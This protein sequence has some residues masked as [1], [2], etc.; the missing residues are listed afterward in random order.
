[1]LLVLCL[2]FSC[3]KDILT[4]TDPNKGNVTFW[5]SE[6]SGEV[7]ILDYRDTGW[8]LFV[9]NVRIGS[10]NKP[11]D[12]HKTSEIPVCGDNRFTNMTLEKGQHQ[13]YMTRLITG[14]NYLV[15]QTYYFDIK[16]EGCVIVRCVL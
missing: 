16:A 8:V 14:L 7:E 1:M 3:E 6:A 5:T 10:I 11:Y 12:I 13:Y 9:D 2:L 4:E 15:S